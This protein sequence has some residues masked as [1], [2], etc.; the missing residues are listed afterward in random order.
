LDPQLFVVYNA[1]AANWFSNINN[2][3][4]LAVVVQLIANFNGCACLNKYNAVQR[5]LLALYI[6]DVLA[7]TLK[8]AG[9]GCTRANDSLAIVISV[10]C[11]TDR[12]G[13]FE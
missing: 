9:Q 3:V 4:G 13:L 2:F 12:A 8:S 7:S 1:P 10:T 6:Y 11:V 5:C